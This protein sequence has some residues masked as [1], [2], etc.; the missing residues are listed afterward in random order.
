[1]YEDMRK[2]GYFSTVKSYGSGH[3]QV[4]THGES[5]ALFRA[6]NIYGDNIGKNVTIYCDRGTCGICQTNLGYIREFLGLE[7]LTVIN[8][9]GKKFEF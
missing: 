9:N 7:K 4:F 3:A 8:K 6:Y 5:N 2:A 1:M